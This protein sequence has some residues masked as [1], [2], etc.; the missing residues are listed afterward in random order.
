M[1]RPG[2]FDYFDRHTSPS[3][4]LVSPPALCVG[5]Y[6]LPPV[7]RPSPMRNPGHSGP[8]QPEWSQLHVRPEVLL[9]T[10]PR[11]SSSGARRPAETGPRHDE[12]CS[13]ELRTGLVDLFPST[14][15]L[16]PRPPSVTRSC[17]EEGRPK[18]VRGARRSTGH[19]V[20]L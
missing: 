12:W 3:P 6:R 14:P 5:L 16:G 8:V 2:L 19:L 10:L 9:P 7:V 18:R 11:T 1:D 13:R 4:L 17:D 15:C 20:N